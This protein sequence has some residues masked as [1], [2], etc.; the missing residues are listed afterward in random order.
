MTTPRPNTDIQ[1]ES[2]SSPHSQHNLGAFL[3][4]VKR[5]FGD[6]STAQIT[7]TDI[8]AWTN[9]GLAEIATKNRIWEKQVTMYVN[10]NLTSGVDTVTYPSDIALPNDL[11]Q[12]EAVVYQG[13]AL[14]GFN[15][16]R[17]LSMIGTDWNQVGA[18]Q[19]W[20][21]YGGNLRLY[22]YPTLIDDTVAG[23]PSL[24]IYYRAIP[25]GV[26]SPD[27]YIPL[28]DK[29]YDTLLAFVVSKAYELDEDWQAQ[30]IQRQ[31][32]DMNLK[33]LSEETD[34]TSGDFVVITDEYYEARSY[35]GIW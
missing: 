26:S 8:I 11:V 31:Q 19:L 5:Q 4:L 15:F 1:G 25:P 14:T 2:I 29:Y 30:G 22:P 35:G 32:F 28:P 33:A 17:V 12:L 13:S 16:E 10:G 23:Q 9:M 3:R 20:Y 7:D 21:M 6:E 34:S 18:P 24:T 27:D